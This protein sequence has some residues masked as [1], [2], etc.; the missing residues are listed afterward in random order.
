[1]DTILQDTCNYLIFVVIFIEHCN[2][3]P[4]LIYEVIKR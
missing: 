3:N 4:G 2:R 1:M